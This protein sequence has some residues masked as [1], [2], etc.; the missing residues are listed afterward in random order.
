MAE[1]ASQPAS[2]PGL[3]PASRGETGDRRSGAGGKEGLGAQG[4]S[5]PPALARRDL[6]PASQPASQ[7]ARPTASLQG[8]QEIGAQGPVGRKVSALKGHPPPPALARRDL[9]PASQ[10]ARPRA[11]LQG[12]N[13]RSALRASQPARPRAS[14]Q[15]ETGDRRSGAGGKEGLGAQGPSPHRPLHAETF[16]PPASQPASQPGLEPASRG[17]TGDRRSGAA[18]AR[19]RAKRGERE[20]ALK[21]W[22][23]RKVSA[24]KGCH[25]PTGPWTPRP[26][27]SASQPASQPARPRASL[28]GKQEIG[29][30][31]QPAS[32]PGLEP[33]SRGKQEIGAQ[34]PVGRKVSALKGHPHRPLHAETFLPPASQP[35]SQ[36]GLEPASRGETGDRRSGAASQPASQPGLEPASR[37]KQEIGAQGPVG[38]KVSALKGHP[39]RALARRDLLPL[40]PA[41]QP[42]S[43]PGLEPASRGNRRSALRGRW[44]GRSRRSRAIPPHRPLHAE[45]FLPPASQPASQ[46]GLE[47]ASRGETGDRR[48]GAGG[49][50]GLG[51]QG[52]SPPT[53]PCT[54][55]PS[56]FAASQALS[57]K[58]KRSSA[59]RGRWEGR[60]RRSRA[61]PPHR[62]LH[63]ETF[64]PPASQPARPRASLQGGNRRSALRG[65]QPARPRASLQG[66]QEIGAQGQVGRKVSALKGHPPTGPCTPRPSS[67][68]ASQPASQ[69]ARPRASLQGETGDRR[70]GA[71]GKEGLGAQGL[72]SAAGPSTP[73]PSFPAQPARPRA[74]RG[75]DEI[76]AQGPPASQPA[77]QASSQKGR[78]GIGARGPVG[79]K[80]SALKGH[81]H[82]PLHAETFF[83]CRQPASQPGLEPASRGKQEI[84]AQGPVGRKVSALKGHPP[85]GPS[86]P[87]PF[88]PPASSQA[89][90]QGG[91]GR[92]GVGAQGLAGGKEGLGAQGPSPHRPLHAETFLPPARQPGLEP[93]S[94]G[95]TGDR[96]SGAGGKEGLGAQG[97]SPPTGPCTPRPSSFAASQPASQPARPRA[98][99]QGETGD[100]RSGAGGKEG[101]GAQGPS[102]HRPLHAETFFLCR[103]PASQPGLEPASRG[104]TGD[105]RSGAASQPASQPGL[106]PASRGETGDRRSG[107][108]GKEGLGAQGPSPPTGP[109]TPRPSSRQPASQA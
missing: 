22:R 24:L 44:E 51:A 57:Q 30:Q 95:E 60:S 16:L 56:S 62:P 52:P 64:L 91:G 74:R 85:T 71:G 81:P 35:A 18:T 20:S 2:Q 59:L 82:R 69:P 68:A 107:A 61:I 54:P 43:Q 76:G 109:C 32:Q 73:R 1:A 37:G 46:P 26:S 41:S 79:R 27:S 6:P 13:R 21:G 14:L 12:G 103:Q 70:S 4:P 48:S 92:E 83:L 5:P 42:A 9:P 72:P 98:S 47:P 28:Q 88:L 90:T 96:R 31:G 7:P 108:G 53:G 25:P 10:P 89:Q 84:G 29:A 65:R 67:F 15:G 58:G 11:S 105:R 50:E 55:R 101:L 17:E 45:T 102:P 106:E 23:E 8:K 75:K 104:E 39:P 78:E 87:R 86:T 77:S 33:A 99:L 63:A 34:G 80:V 93:A 3:E 49:K 19:P 94:R 38:R 36:P 40:P 100:R 66:K 97:S